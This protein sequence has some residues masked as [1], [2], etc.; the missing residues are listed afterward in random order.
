LM[1]KSELVGDYKR[2]VEAPPRRRMAVSKLKG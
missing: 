1:I 2:E